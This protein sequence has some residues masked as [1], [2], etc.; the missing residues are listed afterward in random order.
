M[1]TTLA[2]TSPTS[3]SRSVGIVSSQ[4]Q[5]TEFSFIS[6]FMEIILSHNTKET[7]NQVSSVGIVTRQQTGQAGLGFW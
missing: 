3:S 6:N 5:A 7:G 2:L 4:T 1:L